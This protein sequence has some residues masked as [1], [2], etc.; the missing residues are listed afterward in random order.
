MLLQNV[1]LSSTLN[2][3]A[4]NT[5]KVL[6]THD[7]LTATL[8]KREQL[9]NRYREE[10]ELWKKRVK[11]V[12]NRL[13][14]KERELSRKQTELDNQTSVQRLVTP[15]ENSELREIDG[16]LSQTLLEKRAANERLKRKPFL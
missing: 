2:E 16:Q 3:M 7:D 10:I 9:C 6:A 1:T 14:Q 15:K 4:E 11:F 5:A 8:R 13:T 12:K